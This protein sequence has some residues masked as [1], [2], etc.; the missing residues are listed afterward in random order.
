M[1]RELICR[2]AA[3]SCSIGWMGLIAY[4]D[5]IAQSPVAAEVDGVEITVRDVQRL[6]KNSLRGREIAPD[7]L[8]TMVGTARRMTPIVASTMV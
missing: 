3:V 5:A 4:S 2:A 6:I 7:A 1:L 8:A